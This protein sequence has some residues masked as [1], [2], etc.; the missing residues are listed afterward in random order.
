MRKTW[1]E[2]PQHFI[3]SAE[4]KIGGDEILDFVEQTN[5]LFV[6]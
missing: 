4:Q 2:L 1:E 6:Q 5:K 3:T